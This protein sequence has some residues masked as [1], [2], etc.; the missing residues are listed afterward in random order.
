MLN[1]DS[2]NK[3]VLYHFLI[4][5]NPFAPHLSEELNEVLF[6][7]NYSPINDKKWPEYDESLMVSDFM[8][9]AVQ[10]DGKTRGTV[11]IEASA[12]KEEIFNFVINNDKFSKYLKDCEIIKKIYVPNRLVNL[13]IK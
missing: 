11:Q 5:L 10:I 13:V 12:V 7:D 9:I 1:Q 3:E 4:I 6:K 2:Y 8:V